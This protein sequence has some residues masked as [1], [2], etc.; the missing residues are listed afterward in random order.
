KPLAA[1]RDTLI[2]MGFAR[3]GD[4]HESEDHVSALCDVMR[5]LITG[6]AETPPAALGLQ[7]EF[8]RRHIAPWHALLTGAI[9]G[10]TQT[11]FYKHVAHVLREYFAIESAAFEMG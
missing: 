5:F 8:F 2:E 3:R 11:S 9:T 4:R 10:A 6:D 1:L 7:R